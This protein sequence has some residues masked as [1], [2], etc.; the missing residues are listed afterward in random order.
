M[1]GQ[2]PRQVWPVDRDGEEEAERR[3][4]RVDAGRL[5]AGLGLVDLK[6]PDVFDGRRIGGT[7][8]EGSKAAHAADI[9]TLRLTSQT[10][11]GHVLEHTLTQR[12]DGGL[13]GW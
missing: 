5:H 12:A 13:N 1:M 7:P 8:E 3:N 9:V 10:A 4:R 11:H 2:P 6:P